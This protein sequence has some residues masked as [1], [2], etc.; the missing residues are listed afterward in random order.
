MAGARNPNV[1]RRFQ[2]APIAKS[3]TAPTS[4][5][6][7]RQNQTR[8]SGGGILNLE[9]NQMLSNTPRAASPFSKTGPIPNTQ[10]VGHLQG[11]GGTGSG[12]VDKKVAGIQ[13]FYG[14]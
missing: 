13:K 4:L 8:D 14:R 2:G 1:G 10:A 7:T 11:I 5:G 12:K 6:T 9:P 3:G